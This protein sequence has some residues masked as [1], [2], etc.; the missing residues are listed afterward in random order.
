MAK[1]RADRSEIKNG[2]KTFEFLIRI[3]HMHEFARNVSLRTNFGI[4]QKVN[5]IHRASGVAS[6]CEHN[7][8]GRCG[9]CAS[10]LVDIGLNKAG[11][12]WRNRAENGSNDA[13]A[14]LRRLT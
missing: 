6:C 11:C 12:N 1:Q 7:F 5:A 2:I 10:E 14:H 4:W 13:E 3:P 9:E 8:V